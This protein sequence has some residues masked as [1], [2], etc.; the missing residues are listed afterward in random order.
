[1][2]TMECTIL[3]VFLCVMAEALIFIYAIAAALI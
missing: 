1:M 2:T 3:I